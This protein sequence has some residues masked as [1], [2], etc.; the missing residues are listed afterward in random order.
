MTQ[1]ISLTTK[2]V[3]SADGTS[4]HAQAAGSHSNPAVIC[5]HGFAST[6][7]AFSKQFSNPALLETVYLVAYDVR[8]NGRS[9][10]PVDEESYIS[11]RLAED[12]KAVC[13]AFRVVRP[14]VLGWC[15]HHSFLASI[16]LTLT[17]WIMPQESRRYVYGLTM[18]PQVE[19]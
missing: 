9:D 7:F 15:A 12:F 10:R 8:G 18:R 17:A 11:E 14:I 6:S 2:V 16:A 5:I 3:K 4:I 1:T 19:R 13:E